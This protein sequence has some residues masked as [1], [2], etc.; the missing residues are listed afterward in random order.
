MTENQIYVVLD[1]AL[2]DERKVEVLPGGT[3]DAQ[4][5]EV[6]SVMRQGWKEMN[7]RFVCPL[8]LVRLCS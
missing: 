6:G 8:C 3:K 4:I 1:C 7:D 2:C 5:I